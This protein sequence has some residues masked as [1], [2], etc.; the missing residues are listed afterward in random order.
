MINKYLYTDMV[1]LLFIVLELS[2]IN[3]YFHPNQWK[4]DTLRILRVN[5]MFAPSSGAE[6]SYRLMGY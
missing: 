5:F 1:L 6:K 3:Q 2:M 4:V